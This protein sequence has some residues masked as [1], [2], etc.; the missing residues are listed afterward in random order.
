MTP[1]GDFSSVF[2]L[3]QNHTSKMVRLAAMDAYMWNNGD[4]TEAASTLLAHVNVAE[5]KFVRRPRRY[6]GM[7]AMAFEQQ[8]MALYAA[9]PADL[10]PEP[11]HVESG[12]LDL[13]CAL[14]NPDAGR[15][16]AN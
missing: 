5:Q 4:T 12:P 2:N 15:P 16:D 14:N 8:L 13:S 1:T 10:P 7:D 6:R 9:N 3:S 11:V